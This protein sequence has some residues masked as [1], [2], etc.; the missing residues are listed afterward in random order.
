M[1]HQ[2]FHNIVALLLIL[3]DDKNS[4]VIVGHRIG[5][6]QG[7]VLR[8]HNRREKRLDFLFDLININ[9]THH[10]DGLIVRT[11]PFLV[12]CLQERTLEV[13]DNLHQ[14]DRHAMTVFR[15]R[16]QLGQVALQ[17]THLGTGTQSP[18]LVN[19]A[20][21]LLYFLLFQQQSIS[22]IEEYQ[23]TRVNDTL[24]GCGYITY[25][26]YRLVYRSISIQVRAELH[27]H[28]LTPAQHFVALEVL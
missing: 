19:H 5:R 22:P 21:F 24:T 14:S 25:I 13:V 7:T 1:F 6:H 12:V 27:T 2:H 8:Q 28:A 15:V 26:I 10:D 4:L 23:Q 18:L 17:H 16:I 20:T 3:V 9:I 11:I